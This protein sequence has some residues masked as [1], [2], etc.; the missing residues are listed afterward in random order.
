[1]ASTSGPRMRLEESLGEKLGE[2]K[3]ARAGIGDPTPQHWTEGSRET[4][5]QLKTDVETGE[6]SRTPGASQRPR[7][8]GGC[9]WAWPTGGCLCTP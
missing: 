9:S 7:D 6:Q 3:R 2:R 4:E 8:L 1:M 5:G